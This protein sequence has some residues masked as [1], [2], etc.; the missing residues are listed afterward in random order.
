MDWI[1][2][3]PGTG[4]S[5]SQLRFSVD[6]K[7]KINSSADARLALQDHRAVMGG[8][9]PMDHGHALGKTI[10]VLQ[11]TKEQFK[12]KEL[13]DLRKELELLLG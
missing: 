11:K 8:H 5:S 9:D 3:R 7:V 4:Q 1:E 12:N 10:A 13:G 2:A 6:G